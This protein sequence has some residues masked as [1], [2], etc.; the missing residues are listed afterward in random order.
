MEDNWKVYIKLKQHSLCKTT[1]IELYI[2][3]TGLIHLWST[4]KQIVDTSLE[5]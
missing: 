4:Y 2:G 5:V 3:V 1:Q